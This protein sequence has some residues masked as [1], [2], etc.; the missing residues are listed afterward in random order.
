MP[1]EDATVL[2][3]AMELL[4]QLYKQIVITMIIITADMDASIMGRKTTDNGL[5]VLLSRGAAV[6]QW[7]V[8]NGQGSHRLG[9]SARQPDR[10]GKPR[11]AGSM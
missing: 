1:C 6:D 8:E 10:P 11:R 9:Q 7:A 4:E 2:A 3:G 5:G